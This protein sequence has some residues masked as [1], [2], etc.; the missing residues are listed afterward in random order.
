MGAALQVTAGSEATHGW[1]LLDLSA[2]S[3]RRVPLRESTVDVTLTLTGGM[4]RALTGQR[5]DAMGALTIPDAAGVTSV[6]VVDRH[7]NAGTATP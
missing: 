5:T 7:G 6:R 3:I 2:D 4:T 1:R